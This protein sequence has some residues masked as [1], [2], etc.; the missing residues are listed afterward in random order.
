VASNYAADMGRNVEQRWQRQRHFT[1][2]PFTQ[3]RPNRDMHLR[4]V[5]ASQ[6]P[7]TFDSF[8]GLPLTECRNVRPM[9]LHA[10]GPRAGA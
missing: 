5:P 8:A 3:P 9:G 4:T 2:L 10:L 7:E 1:R 6:N